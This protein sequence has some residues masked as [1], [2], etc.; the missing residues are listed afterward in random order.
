MW[1]PPR[2]RVIR[3]NVAK[4]RRLVFLKKELKQLRN[5]TW[6]NGFC[7]RVEPR[8]KIEGNTTKLSMKKRERWGGRDLK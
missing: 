6:K 1:G 8:K 7:A 5:C 3:G 2:M 4:N